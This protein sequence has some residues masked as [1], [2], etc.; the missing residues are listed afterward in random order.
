M[1]QR[2][3]SDR[4][5]F[6]RDVYEDGDPQPED[7]DDYVRACLA[8]I[9]ELEAYLREKNEIIKAYADPTGMTPEDVAALREEH[10]R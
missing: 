6:I 7:K 8:R 2:I 3:L 1:T 5:A 4:V 10:A 9:A